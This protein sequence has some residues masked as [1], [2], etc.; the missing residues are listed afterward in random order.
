MMYDSAA[1]LPRVSVISQL[2]L[3]LAI[4]SNLRIV[5]LTI[6]PHDI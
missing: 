5:N 3:A 2:D 6:E 4:R 1:P